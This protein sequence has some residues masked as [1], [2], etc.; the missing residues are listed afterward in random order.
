[1]MVVEA[2]KS[3]HAMRSEAETKACLCSGLLRFALA[4]SLASTL[5]YCDDPA[6]SKLYY[7]RKSESIS[8]Y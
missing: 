8:V 5:L 6:Y 1:M 2:E 3:L 4:K 7:I